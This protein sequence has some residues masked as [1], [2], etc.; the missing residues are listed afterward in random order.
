MYKKSLLFKKD[1]VYLKKK[2]T[3]FYVSSGYGTAV[4]PIR[5]GNNPEIVNIKIN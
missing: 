5:G 3:H 4:I 1:R 2:N